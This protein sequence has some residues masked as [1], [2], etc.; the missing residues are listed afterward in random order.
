MKSA[1]IFRIVFLLAAAGFGAAVVRAEDPQAVKSRM[2]QRLGAVDAL[3]DRQAAGENN[4]GFLEARGSVSAAD[5]KV[6]SDENADRRQ[7]YLALAASTKS[8]AETVGRQR[9]QQ[10]AMRSKAGVWLQSASGEW[11]QKQ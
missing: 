2:D 1:L 11:S 8:D 5:Q 4:R 3:R 10:L 7:V 6:I 9:A